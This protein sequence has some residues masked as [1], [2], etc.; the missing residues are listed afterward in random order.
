MEPSNGHRDRLNSAADAA[1]I[2]LENQLSGRWEF[3]AKAS[4]SRQ[5]EMT[6]GR[7][8]EV[9]TVEETGVAVRTARNGK[10]GF[11]AA[12]GLEG[13]ASRRAVEGALTTETPSPIDPLPPPRLLGVR[14]V[15]GPGALPPKGWAGHVAQEL[16][17][18]LAGTAGRHAR[19]RRT[20]ISE[21]TYAWILATGEGW[22][23]RHED[24]ST[25]LLAEIEIEGE[26]S[27]I[28][29]DWLHIPDHKSFDPEAAAAQVSDRALLTR[30]RVATDSGLRD[31]ILHPEVAAQLLAA[32]APLFLAAADDEEH[33]A[34]LVDPEGRLATS[35]LTLVDDRTDPQA[36]I[37]GPCDGEG[38]PARR[39]LL[40]DE[41]VPRY[42]LASHRDAVRHSETSRG[43]ALRLSYRDYPATGIANLEVATE[44][45][46]AAAELLGSADR[47]LYLLRPLASVAFEPSSD[48]YRIIASGVWLDGHTVRG[49]HPVVELRG[50]LGRLLRRIEAVGTD[51]R[52]FQTSRGFVGAPSLLIRRQPVVG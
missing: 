11:A 35:V 27:G 50:S 23:A 8:L 21:G 26:R 37:T 6:P 38:L 41:G 18:A 51:L 17:R 15:Q 44:N 52:W 22:V 46:V 12:S 33:L 30:N 10:A 16:E 31:L 1:R 48:S 34:A 13:E 47:A 14:E 43:G 42:R 32:M 2:E 39:T 20:V 3:F 29:R 19:L 4:I 45:G 7:P 24:T 49:W 5:V 28:W 25:A 40:V 9:I 36:P